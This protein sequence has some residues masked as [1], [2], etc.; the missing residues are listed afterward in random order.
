M[1]GNRTVGDV[2]VGEKDESY[3]VFVQFENPDLG[4]GEKQICIIFKY[5][6]E[7]IRLYIPHEDIFRAL[8]FPAE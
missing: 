7:E 8:K 1:L 3:E 5:K 2:F 6:G 4:D